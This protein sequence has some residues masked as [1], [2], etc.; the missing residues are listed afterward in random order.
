[1]GVQDTIDELTGRY[2]LPS[3]LASEIAALS[4]HDISELAARVMTLDMGMDELAA[5][6][7]VSPERLAEALSEPGYKVAVRPWTEEERAE[8]IRLTTHP[9]TT[10]GEL[11]E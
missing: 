7:G 5:A 11:H 3:D 2:G 4:N 6:I 9:D 8:F 1:M 10:K